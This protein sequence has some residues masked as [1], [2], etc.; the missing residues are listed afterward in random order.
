MSPLTLLSVCFV[1][2]IGLGLAFPV[3]TY[4]AC[5]ALVAGAVLV[6]V[7]F[8]IRRLI[9]P[10]LMLFALVPGWIRSP[11]VKPPTAMDSAPCDRVVEG[12]ISQPPSALEAGFRTVIEITRSTGCL[13]GPQR[14][15]LKATSGMLYLSI[16]EGTAPALSRGDRVLLRSVVRPLLQP[17]NPGFPPTEDQPAYYGATVGSAAGVIITATPSFEP[18]QFFDR[19]R[20]ALALRL[21]AGLDKDTAALAK[22]FVLGETTSL[23][24]QTKN[25]F[26]RTGCA[27]LLAVSGLHLGLVAALSF[28][29]LRRLLLRTPLAAAMDTGR[30]AACFALVTT[31]AFTLLTGCK[32]PVMRACVMASAALIARAVGR[33]QG[34]L[35]AFF[36]AA[37]AILCVTPNALLE[38][39]FQLSFTATAAFFFVFSTRNSESQDHGANSGWHTRLRRTASRFLR[40]AVAAAAATS[41]FALYHFGSVSWVAPLS[42]LLAVPL[43]EF[44]IMPL[45]LSALIVIAC[46]PVAAPWVLKPA[47]IAIQLLDGILAQ[48]AVLPC[49]IDSPGPLLS[50]LIVLFCGTALIATAFVKRPRSAFVFSAV[51]T[52]IGV[53]IVLLRTNAFTP[54][55]LTVHF[56]DVGQGDSAL[57]TSPK[58]RHLL[59]DGGPVSQNGTDAGERI[60]IPALRALGVTEIDLTAATHP[61]ADHIGGLAA[62]L[63][64]FP[65]RRHFDNGQGNVGDDKPLYRNLIS[66]ATRNRIPIHRTPAIC[67]VHEFDG[68]SFAV[69]HPCDWKNGFDPSAS[70]NDNS[71]ILLVR[72]KKVSLLLLGD[73]GETVEN[74]LVKRGRLQA[75]DILK[76]SHHGSKTATSATLLDTVRPAYAVISVGRYNRFGMPHRDVLF[77]LHTRDI[78][79]LRT[80]LSGAIRISTDGWVIE[81]TPIHAD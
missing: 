20:V 57:L 4:P 74:M 44:A 12:V 55:M 24:L 45:L 26:R 79:V 32:I 34:S 5:S 10:C 25:R 61:D 67:G 81:I 65:V 11:P 42:N 69:L 40:A 77:R 14:T 39:G 60:V 38:A 41:P 46:F 73:A 1:V 58:G 52:V 13:T 56:F 2:G 36:L 54:G 72:Y 31:I 49:T 76:A 8:R 51:L 15:D 7:S 47:S 66:T 30:I 48:I 22:A 53:A 68:A 33:P 27:H 70:T 21:D 63:N 28:L 50:I 35:E 43:T 64:S 75:V 6:A 16:S 59:L 17:E 37:A 62:V 29:L 9:T 23:S 18:R 3:P 78:R 80:D 71:L 19:R